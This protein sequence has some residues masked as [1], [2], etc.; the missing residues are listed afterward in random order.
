MGVTFVSPDQAPF[1]EKVMPLLDEYRNDPDFGGLL[2]Q[3]LETE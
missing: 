2:T 3:I 1:R